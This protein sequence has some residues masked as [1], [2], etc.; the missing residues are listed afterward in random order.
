MPRAT[1]GL[2]STAPGKCLE[3]RS[4]G[5]AA[6]EAT[7][8]F[9]MQCT[10]AGWVMAVENVP[11]VRRAVVCVSHVCVCVCVGGV[12]VDQCL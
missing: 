10:R 7:S 9:G 4:A 2:L 5:G 3:A 8:V 1:R 12:G 6:K 11:L